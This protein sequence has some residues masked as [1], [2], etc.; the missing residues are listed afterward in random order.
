MVEEENKDKDGESKIL[1]VFA[2]LMLFCIG[3]GIIRLEKHIL[4]QNNVDRVQDS[5]WNDMYYSIV[6]TF[7]K[8][9]YLV[10]ATT[11]NPTIHQ[12][13]SS[14]DRTACNNKIDLKNPYKHKYIGLSR[15]LAA[16]FYCGEKV[17]LINCGKFSGYYTIADFGNK[18]LVR[19]IDI[20]VGKEIGGK[21]KNVI[22]RHV[23]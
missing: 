11:Y 1:M 17:Q 8:E 22:L 21:F 20:L 4:H 9:A 14:P 6:D 10:T 18:R 19:T 2:F 13:D 23:N 3:G 7:E 5:L 15:D 12:C 16:E